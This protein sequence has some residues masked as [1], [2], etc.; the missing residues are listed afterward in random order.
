[1]IIQSKVLN[2]VVSFKT[3]TKANSAT[4]NLNRIKIKTNP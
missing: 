4:N 2:K 1:M 3:T